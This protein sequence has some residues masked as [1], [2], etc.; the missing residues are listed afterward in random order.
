MFPG[1]SD[2]GASPRA[3]VSE[4]LGGSGVINVLSSLLREVLENRRLD[5]FTG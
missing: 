2:I 3:S 5:W 1:F 4:R